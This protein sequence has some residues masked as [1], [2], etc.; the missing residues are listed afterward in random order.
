MVPLYS[1]VLGRE[2]IEIMDSL[3]TQNIPDETEDIPQTDEPVWIFG[4]KYNAIKGLID[5]SSVNNFNK[6]DYKVL[7]FRTGYDT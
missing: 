2:K 7:N 5:N 1:Q 4:K 6:M 3:F